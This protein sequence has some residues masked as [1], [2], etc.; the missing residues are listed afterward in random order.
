MDID[1]L[2]ILETKIVQKRVIF[3]FTYTEIS[4]TELRTLKTVDL[5]ESV[6]KSLRKKEVTNV[7]FVFVINSLELT[8]N[9]K[10]F[11]QFASIFRSYTDVIKQKLDFTIVQTNNGVFKLFF[12]LFKRY[13]EPIKPLYMCDSNESVEKCLTSSSERNK[14]SDLS[15]R[16]IK[17]S[18]C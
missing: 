2:L 5:M 6:L 12:S 8:T 11:E 18:K 13:Y 17:E 9:I 16:I 4:I 3:K 14:I 15:E 1:D 10:L 7:C